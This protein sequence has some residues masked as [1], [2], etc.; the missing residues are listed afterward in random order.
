MKPAPKDWPR[1]SS[2]VFYEDAPAMID[3]LMKAFDFKLK[4]KV[5]G[6]KPGV[7]IHAELTY[8]EAIIMV[9]SHSKLTGNRFGVPFVSPKEA[10]GNTQTIMLHVPDVDAHHAQAKAAG[11][12]IV[13]EP[14]VSDY[15]PEYWC[16]KGYGAK[17]PEGHLWWFA[18]RL[19]NPPGA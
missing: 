19:R 1:L 14:T 11:V 13:M 7:I 3:W 8:G 5:E 9:C 4:I 16:D 2:S 10:G 18:E 15:G 17:D 6:D 12:E